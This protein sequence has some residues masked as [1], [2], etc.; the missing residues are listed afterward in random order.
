MMCSHACV[1]LR[2]PSEQPT[3]L[4]FLLAFHFQLCKVC[5]VQKALCSVLFGAYLCTEGNVGV[6][7]AASMRQQGCMLQPEQ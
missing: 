7:P 6:A 2:G 1:Q 4:D 5:L 3:L